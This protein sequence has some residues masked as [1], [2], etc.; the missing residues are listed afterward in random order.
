MKTLHNIKF[1]LLFA[2]F[3]IAASQT[4]AQD[5]EKSEIL[6]TYRYFVKNNS[7]QY[8]QVQ[9]KI[10]TDNRL[11]AMPGVV[12]KLFLDGNAPENLIA[13]VRTN[14]KGEAKAVL[15]VSLKAIWDSS[16]THKFLAVVEATSAEE[17]TTTELDITKVKIVLDTASQEGT[18][19]VTAQV[20][21]FENGEWAPASDVELKIG[22]SRLGGDIKI[23]EEESY[24]TDSLGKAEGEFKIDSLPA[25][26]KKGNIMLIA[27]IE[28]NERYGNLSVEK[29]VPWGVY[30]L[31]KDNFNQRSLW[32]T[33]DKTPVWL[34]FMAYSIMATVW[35]VIFYLVFQL[36]KIRKIGKSKVAT[37]EDPVNAERELI[38]D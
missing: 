3:L 30:F 4:N 13:K 25:V 38:I 17:E 21:S 35:G 7:F 2:G 23:G 9:T 26:D 10:K 5:E 15:P 22:V 27:K 18:R 32:G 19:M 28:D 37:V 12:L 33:R 16:S 11:Q 1:V 20:L 29:T 14:E 24:I 36:I 31:R 6:V 34:L 8:L